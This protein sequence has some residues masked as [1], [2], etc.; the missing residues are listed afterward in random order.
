MSALATPFVWQA[1]W[2]LAIL[3]VHLLVSLFALGVVTHLF[4]ELL[5]RREPRPLSLTRYARWSA[6]SY[7]LT[8][9]IG[10][11]IYPTYNA[12]VRASKGKGLERFVDA[13]VINNGL[14]SFARWAVGLFEIKEHLATFALALLP[15]VVLCGLRFEQLTRGER[16]SFRI[17]TVI[18]TLF[19]YYAFIS[20]GIVTA[21]RGIH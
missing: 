16:I 7:A 5:F 17:V 15:W 21:V 1:P 6:I 18:F 13:G 4:W 8:W 2:G 3:I 12:L 9:V 20:G 10:I 14:E 11:I 19:V